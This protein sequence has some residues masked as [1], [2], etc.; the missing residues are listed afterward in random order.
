M[1]YQNPSLLVEGQLQ[2]KT[3]F[4]HMVLILWFVL[5]SYPSPV[6]TGTSITA[7][8]PWGCLKHPSISTQGTTRLL[9]CKCWL[10][11]GTLQVLHSFSQG[12]NYPPICTLASSLLHVHMPQ[13]EAA[14]RWEPASCD[15]PKMHARHHTIQTTLPTSKSRQSFDSKWH[16]TLLFSSKF[17]V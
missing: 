11:L 1:E 5:P 10:P 9:D 4:R 16:E 8:S 17:D 7:I 14:K 6:R 12:S 2:G 3:G 13:V 15:S